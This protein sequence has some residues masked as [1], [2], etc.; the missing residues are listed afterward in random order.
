ML[1]HLLDDAVR[2][3]G[4]VRAR[5]RAVRHMHRV[6]HTGRND[7]RM[8]IVIQGEHIRNGAHQINARGIIDID[9]EE[10]YLLMEAIAHYLYAT[11]PAFGAIQNNIR[12]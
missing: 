10:D 12:K 7:L 4:D 1:C 11:Y 9:S 5:K 2:Y 6:A 3:R 8:D